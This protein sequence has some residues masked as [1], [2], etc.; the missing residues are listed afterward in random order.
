MFVMGLELFF[1]LFL[2]LGVLIFFFWS[3][4][5]GGFY[6]FF[7]PFGLLESNFSEFT[8]TANRTGPVD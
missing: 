8:G 3:K 4:G 1:G 5:L 7:F 2:G 6:S